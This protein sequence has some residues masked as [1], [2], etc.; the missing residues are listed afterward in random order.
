MRSS[1]F[2]GVRISTNNNCLN[3]QGNPR[4]ESLWEVALEELENC[5]HAKAIN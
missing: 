4:E 2:D 3:E 1:S 5:G